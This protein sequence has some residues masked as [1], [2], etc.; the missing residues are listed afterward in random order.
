MGLTV[1]NRHDVTQLMSMIDGIPPIRGVRGR[2][3]QRPDKLYA[4][5]GY[6]YDCYRRQL[7]ARGICQVRFA[8]REWPSV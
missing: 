8:L 4:D 7:R 2:P 5:Q 6:D 1:G 3:R